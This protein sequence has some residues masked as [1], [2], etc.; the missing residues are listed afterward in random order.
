M[1]NLFSPSAYLEILTIAW[2]VPSETS[3]PFFPQPA[4]VGSPLQHLKLGQ[5]VR[6]VNVSSLG[7]YLLFSV[8]P[9]ALKY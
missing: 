7:E 4:P 5:E 9:L 1:S 2:T 8:C 6:R 3:F